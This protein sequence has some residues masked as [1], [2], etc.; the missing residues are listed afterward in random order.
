MYTMR[1]FIIKM[2]SGLLFLTMILMYGC[3]E[4]DITDDS[5]EVE[6]KEI[7]SIYCAYYNLGIEKFIC[8]NLVNK[9]LI[10]YPDVEIEMYDPSHGDDNMSEEDI[11][12]NLSSDLLAGKGPDIVF[13]HQMNLSTKA[14]CSG[15]FLDL[16]QFIDNDENFNLDN[17]EKAAMDAGI[18]DGKRI[19]I[20][21]AYNLP[22]ILSSTEKMNSIGIDSSLLKNSNDILN[23]L[24]TSCDMGISPMT[25]T[26]YKGILPFLALNDAFDYS[27]STLT[28]DKEYLKSFID[29]LV[30]IDKLS[31][32]SS[33]F[34][35]DGKDAYYND[36]LLYTDFNLY[37]HIRYYSEAGEDCV[38]IAP[39]NNSGGS[40]A[41]VSRFFLINANSKHQDTSWR[42]IQFALS[43][44]IQK[45]AR[46]LGRIPIYS[47]YR[48]DY[49]DYWCNF[50]TDNENV[51]I[52]KM[53]DDFMVTSANVTDALIFSQHTDLCMFLDRFQPYIDGTQTFDSC[54][55][56][57]VSYF[58]IYLSE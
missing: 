46:I 43:S 30:E 3:E 33:S 5:K 21:F 58:S 20:P 14:L 27:Y 57:A 25:I 47:E 51:D 37:N 54:Y 52:G 16:N 12:N 29:I 6:Q 44:E 26:T 55:D 32:D 22:Y 28:I 49:Y 38:L 48:K 24:R 19:F 45:E 41:Y 53:I 4:Q 7:I 36:L 2:I 31:D 34:P 13:T 11:M 23:M 1:K 9:F 8:D 10:K 35:V 15:A 39:L 40:T 18:I 17:Y 56:E 50:Y 42:F